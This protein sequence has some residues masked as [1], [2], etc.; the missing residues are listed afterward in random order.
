MGTATVCRTIGRSLGERYR[1]E[2]ESETKVKRARPIL[3]CL[4][5]AL[6]ISFLPGLITLF[7]A[8]ISARTEAAHYDGPAFFN[9]IFWPALALVLAW[10]V[11][12]KLWKWLWDLRGRRLVHVADVPPG[13]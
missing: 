6:L 12:T 10:I 7:I 9:S 5:L 3:V 2:S 8:I 1:P 11:Q 13:A 4:P